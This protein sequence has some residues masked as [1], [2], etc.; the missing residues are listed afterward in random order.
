MR[1]RS[2]TAAKGAVQVEALDPAPQRPVHDVEH[3]VAVLRAVTQPD[4]SRERVRV[5]PA[6]L[7]ARFTGRVR[8]DVRRLH[9]QVDGRGD[10]LLGG[11]AHH[12]PT[13]RDS[14]HERMSTDIAAP[15]KC[16][17]AGVT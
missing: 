5:E 7:V 6:S 13:N 4:D 14:E 3:A 9:G 17:G 15:R 10:D 2:I 11:H 16:A 12:P 1:A 8:V